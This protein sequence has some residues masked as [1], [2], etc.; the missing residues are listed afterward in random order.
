MLQYLFT[1]NQLNQYFLVIHALHMRPIID[2][3]NRRGPEGLHIME[4]TTWHKIS[5]AS[6]IATKST[7]FC[8]NISI[9]SSMSYMQKYLNIYQ[10]Y[11]Q[12][13][14]E[15]LLFL[16]SEY[17][18]YLRSNTSALSTYRVNL[19]WE[20]GWLQYT[21]LQHHLPSGGEGQVSW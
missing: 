9:S 19:M 2:D 15:L 17:Q 7:T 3:I 11:F 18:R 13:W 1:Q 4:V 10:L 21:Q 12:A 14:G 8:I 6:N 20:Q 16:H 5:E